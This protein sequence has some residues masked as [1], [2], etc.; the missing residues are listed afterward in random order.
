M[1]SETLYV[2]VYVPEE[3]VLE[4]IAVIRA[5][6][7]HFPAGWEVEAALTKWCDEEEEHMQR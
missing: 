6:L 5:G 2:P 3:H 4:V 1:P 7:T